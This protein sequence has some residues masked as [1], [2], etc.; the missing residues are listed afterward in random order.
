MAYAAYRFVP[1]LICAPD[2]LHDSRSIATAAI[3]ACGSTHCV[4]TQVICDD[5][6]ELNKMNTKLKLRPLTAAIMACL[7]GSAFA[8][9][10]DT[11]T[12]AT[13]TVV[14]SGTKENVKKPVSPATVESVDAESLT[15]TTNVMNVEDALKYFPS[16]LVRKRFTG[17]TQEPLASRTTGINASAR[18]LIFAD[19]VLLST[20]VNNNNGNGSPQWFMVSPEEIESI[21][22]MYGPYSAAFAG[23]SYGAVAQ[24]NTRMP[25]KFEATVNVN[26]ATQQVALYGTHD[27][28][29]AGE[30]N[31]TLGNRSDAFSWFISANHLDSTSQ[32][33]TFGTLTKST[34][35]ASPANPVISG[36]YADF[37]RTGGAIQVIGGSN[38]THTIQDTAKTKIAKNEK[39]QLLSE[40]LC[41]SCL[42]G[43]TNHSCHRTGYVHF[44]QQ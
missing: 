9:T 11:T 15:D 7:A 14:I 41:F 20:L 6:I 17:D 40:S 29:K 37:N 22:V 30:L 33:I 3:Q 44:C 26:L 31:A 8:Q 16:V 25:G 2:N 42:Y 38:F 10:A 39:N 43:C 19:G 27:H 13:Q 28:A 34:T 24:I 35:A 23:N 36:A 21:D 4:L 18:T 1:D 12:P 5:H 32:P